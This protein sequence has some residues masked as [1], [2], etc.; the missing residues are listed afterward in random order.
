MS[1]FI[2]YHAECHYAECRYAECLGADKSVYCP[3]FCP[4]NSYSSDEIKF[5]LLSFDH[6]LFEPNVLRHIVLIFLS[7]FIKLFFVV[8]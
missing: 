7:I 2:H 1:R 3:D 4:N 6:V 8:A 5:E